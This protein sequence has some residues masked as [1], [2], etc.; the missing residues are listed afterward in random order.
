MAGDERRVFPVSE[1][2]R[3]TDPAGREE[4]WS[5]AGTYEE[6]PTTGSLLPLPKADMQVK[7]DYK[8]IASFLPNDPSKRFEHRQHDD[9]DH[10]HRRQF[11]DR[12]KKP[13]TVRDTT[14]GKLT[15]PPRQ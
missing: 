8:G 2:R 11:I 1:G 9:R 14:G 10:R 15:P 12:T 7:Y 13:L 6:K 3:G 4:C 5:L